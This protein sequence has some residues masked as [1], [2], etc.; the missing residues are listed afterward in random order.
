MLFSESRSFMFVTIDLESF[1]YTGIHWEGISM[2][3]NFKLVF[4]LFFTG[5]LGFGLA[6]FGTPAEELRFPQAQ[7]VSIA[8]PSQY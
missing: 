6:K 3:F 4:A 2:K 1:L 5:A 7:Q 8:C